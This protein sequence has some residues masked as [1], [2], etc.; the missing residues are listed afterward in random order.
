MNKQH[1]SMLGL[2]LGSSL[3]IAAC[4]DSNSTSDGG[5]A[6]AKGEAGGTS[7][8]GSTGSEA[9]ST[10]DA[11]AAGAPDAPVWLNPQDVVVIGAAPAAL[12]HV[13]VGGTDYMTQSEVASIAL[14]T[15]DIVGAETYADSDTAIVGSAGL[16]FV[17]ERTN[18]KVHLVEAGKIK[19]TFD[20]RDLGTDVITATNKAFVPVLNES[21]VVVLDLAKGTVSHRIDLSKFAAEGDKDLSADIAQGAYDAK[22]GIVY[23]LLQRIDITSIDAGGNLPCTDTK[24]L[25]VGV[26]AKT[27]ELVDLNGDAEGEALELS[28]ANPASMS[29]DDTGTLVTV[30]ANGCVD[31]ETVSRKGIEILDLS[32][33][34]TGTVYEN[35]TTDYLNKLIPLDGSNVLLSL[36]DATFTQHWYNLD[37]AL[38]TLGSELE[39]VPQ[40]ALYD[41]KDLIGVGPAGSVLR[42]DIATQTSTTI[43]ESSWAGDY[44]AVSGTALVE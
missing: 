13:L 29:L 42:Y 12:G 3:A 35:A 19:T 41:G 7:E 20:V 6:G 34:T 9:G 17:L 38:G 8:A 31:G 21:L 5:D 26:D 44:S 11:G 14:E 28:L 1:L 37:L 10:S 30:L 18:D 40:A 25:I 23:F 36:F 22:S 24:A 2:I 15:G 33:G 27:D 4:S 16:G 43:S 39:G 32:D